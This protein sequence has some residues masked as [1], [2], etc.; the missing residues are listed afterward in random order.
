MPQVKQA[1]EVVPGSSHDHS[2]L[3]ICTR[4]DSAYHLAGVGPRTQL[5]ANYILYNHSDARAREVRKGALGRFRN[6]NPNGRDKSVNQVLDTE[7]YRDGGSVPNRLP[8][9]HDQV[10]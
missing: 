5:P 9:D 8:F 10:L 6:S 3:P 7:E 2:H 4:L 1:A